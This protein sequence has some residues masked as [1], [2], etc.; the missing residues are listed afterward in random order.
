MGDTIRKAGSLR[1]PQPRADGATAKSK[2]LRSA[3]LPPRLISPPLIMQCSLQHSDHALWIAPRRD[4]HGSLIIY[5]RYIPRPSAA[6]PRCSPQKYGRARPHRAAS[7][8]SRYSEL[9]ANNLRS[10]TTE[11]IS[12]R[13]WLTRNFCCSPRSLVWPR[14][15]SASST[16]IASARASISLDGV[17]LTS[18]TSEQRYILRHTGYFPCLFR[19]WTDRP[20]H[21]RPFARRQSSIHP[22]FNLH[23]SGSRRAIVFI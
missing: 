15:K 10:Q 12:T 5:R 7:S 18:T 17:T 16:S 6:H 19:T 22:I 23:R 1:W 3:G 11:C 9:I 4:T 8:Q 20:A 2:D 14:T 13:L 21:L